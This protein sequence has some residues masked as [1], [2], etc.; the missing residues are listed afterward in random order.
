MKKNKMCRL[1]SA[2][3]ILVLLTTSIVGSTFAK[4]TTEGS[5]SDTARVA[6]WGVVINTSGSLYSDAYAIQSAADGKGDLPEAWTATPAADAVTVASE[7]EN[8]NIVAPGTKSEGGLSFSI[9]GKPEVAVAVSTTITA[10]DIFLKAGKY[11][12]LVK[13]D[14]NDTESL[15]QLINAKTAGVYKLNAG[16]TTYAKQEAATAAYTAGDQIYFLTDIAEIAP[17]ADYY[18]VK[19]T[20]AGGTTDASVNTAVKAAGKLATTIEVGATAA[21][22]STDYKTAYTDI[23]HTYPANTDLGGG[24]SGPHFGDEKLSWEWKFEDGDD[25]DA[26]AKTNAADTILGSLIAAKKGDAAAKGIVVS[27]DDAAKTA[28]ALTFETGDDDY[29]VK[30]GTDVVANLRTKFDIKLTVT[31]VD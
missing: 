12:V 2:L 30:N 4:Y 3:L 29:T 8:D 1:A 7:I 6:K 24:T 5:A 28:T 20:L 19:Y 15:K 18:P 14:V 23:S 27:V 16:T 21:P 17:D 22:G 9:S 13:A 10:E 11:G 25:D 31:Q 26:K